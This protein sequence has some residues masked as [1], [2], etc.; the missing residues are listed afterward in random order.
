M[1]TQASLIPSLRALALSSVLL[2]AGAAHAG[3][4]VSINLP[5][6]TPVQYY[7]NSTTTTTVYGAPGSQIISTRQVPKTVCR[8]AWPGSSTQQCSTEYVTVED[9]YVSQPPVYVAPAP[10]YVA[11]PVYVSPSVTFGYPGYGYGNNYNNGYRRDRDWN[12]PPHH[13]RPPPGPAP[14]TIYNGNSSGYGIGTY[15]PGVNLQIQGR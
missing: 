12:P 3:W 11:P 2:L 8:P 4:G 6:A 14:R 15:G 7:G 5:I 10:V 9:G 13:H 1:K